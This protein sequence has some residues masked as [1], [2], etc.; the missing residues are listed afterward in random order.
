[1]SQSIPAKRTFRDDINGLRAYAVLAVVLFH[2]KVP[3]FGGGFVGVDIFFVISGFLM[4]GIIVGGLESKNDKGFSLFQFYMAR[5]RRIIPALFVLCLVLLGFGWF[6]VAPDDYDRLA[7]EVDRA[8]LFISNIYYYKKSGYFDTD[9]AE[10]LLLHTWSLSVEWQFYLLYPLL[11]MLL[12]R[13]SLRLILPGIVV[14]LLASFVWSVITSYGN[15]TYAFYLLPSRT[16]EMLVGGL[17]FFASRHKTSL[18]LRS[19]LYYPGLIAI[20][21]SIF[22]YDSD[23]IWPGVPALLPVLGT[24]AIILANQ[25]KPATGNLLFQRAGDWSYSIY[26][27][28]WP[29]AVALVLTDATHSAEVAAAMIALS[30]L[31]GWISYKFIENPLRTH[32]TRLKNLQVLAVMLVALAPVFWAASVVRSNKGFSERLPDEIQAIFQ[33]ERDIYLEPGRCHKAR[34]ATGANCSYGTG[35]TGLIVMG[36][37]HAMSLMKLFVDLYE[38]RGWSVADWSLSGCPTIDGLETLSRKKFSCP[39]FNDQNFTLLKEFP[40]IPVVVVNRFSA[41]LLGGNEPEYPKRPAVYLGQPADWFDDHYAGSIYRGYKKSLCKL[42][43]SNPVYVLRPTPELA[44]HV[45]KV[46]GRSK[47]YKNQTLRVRMEMAEFHERNRMANQLID[48][49]VRDCGVVALDPAP[50]LC[51]E[52]TCY[53]DLDGTPMYF[54]DDHL[55]NLGASRLLPLFLDNLPL[56]SR[57]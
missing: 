43:S 41:H 35:P 8:L 48:E 12:A 42:A 51:G 26:L 54:D 6:L 32:L 27:W 52:D 31:L 50:L 56:P 40:G 24:V 37:S 3:G 55:N 10:R 18:S 29:L 28:H 22:L 47:L 5:V 16:W 21:L 49:L 44:Q 11:L 7:R 15:P 38:P 30:I 17:A 25:S 13:M 33:A 34:E 19:W 57:E 2:F 36:D 46:M 53:G 4:T 23:T 20:L 39:D 45:P 9:A 14:L 1:M